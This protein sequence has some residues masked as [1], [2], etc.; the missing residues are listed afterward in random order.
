MIQVLVN[1]AYRKNLLPNWLA[2]IG[3]FA[4]SDSAVLDKKLLEVLERFQQSRLYEKSPK[5]NPPEHELFRLIEELLGAQ[6]PVRE[7]MLARAYRDVR[8]RFDQ[9]K[10]QHNLLTFDDLLINLDRALSVMI[11]SGLLAGAI[12]NQFPLALIDEFQDT[13]PMQYRI[14]SRIYGGQEGKVSTAEYRPG[15]VMIGD[16]KQAIYAFRGADIFTYIHARRQV[17]APYT[18]DTNWR[19]TSRMVESVNRLF[20]SAN[21]P[22][23]YEQ[24]IQFQGGEGRWQVR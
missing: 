13:D 11:N 10:Q 3:E 15:L 14:F 6:V 17:E 21:A 2:K 1:R 5:G 16:P 22:F 7:I 19:S 12:R 4:E 8:A 24:D 18:L 23:I 20:E 9:H